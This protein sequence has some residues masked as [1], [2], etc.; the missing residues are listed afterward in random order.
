MALLAAPP[1][2]PPVLVGVDFEAVGRELGSFALWREGVIDGA[3][4]YPET[5]G[6][7]DM[8]PIFDAGG[9]PFRTWVTLDFDRTVLSI[10][11][12]DFG[13]GF[14]P[15]VLLREGWVGS[16]AVGVG[17]TLRFEGTIRVAVRGTDAAETRPIA[18]G[19]GFERSPPGERVHRAA[20]TNEVAVRTGGARG[21]YR[22]SVEGRLHVDLH[23][24]TG[25][26]AGD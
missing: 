2:A 24:Y 4:E 22:W 16:D 6:Y 8:G 14:T 11:D 18:F 9:V 21:I 23:V 25:G 19:R 3:P 13:V 10:L 7:V 20:W 5:P 12:G 15:R 1:V 17:G 26:R